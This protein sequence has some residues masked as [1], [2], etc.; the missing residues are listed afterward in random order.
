MAVTVV[1]LPC[2]IDHV[3]SYCLIATVYVYC[4]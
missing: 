2:V 4:H 3:L 1:L